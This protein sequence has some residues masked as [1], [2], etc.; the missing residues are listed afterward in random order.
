[1]NIDKQIAIHI[2]SLRKERGLTLRQL[3]DD[4]G[5]S[6]S[7]I[8]LIERGETSPTAA[9]LNKL[10]DAM[11]LTLAEL[12]TITSD[13]EPARPVSRFSEQPTWKD[14]ASGY[15]RRQVSPST[16]SLPTKLVE[17]RFPPGETV[18][19][20]NTSGTVHIHQQIW[21]IEG[22]MDIAFMEGTWNLKTGDCLAMVLD[23]H[24]VFSNPTDRP[25]RYLLA[26]TTP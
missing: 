25:S 23:Q 14:P 3:A 1:M 24:I 16:L 2:R 4:S 22:E 26:I 12:F 11:G 6:S 15:V 21:V 8:S 20:E 7:M 10:A 13:D 9:V 18:A 19:F 17:V 5:V